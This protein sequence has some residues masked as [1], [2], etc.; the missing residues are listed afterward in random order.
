M[1]REQLTEL[2]YQGLETELGGTQVYETAL[3]C[4]QNDELKEEWEI[5]LGQ[6]K[7]QV[8]IVRRLLEAFEL[9]RRGDDSWPR[10]RPAHWQSLVKAMEMALQ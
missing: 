5:Y 2:L 1:K 6:T 8:E 4:V 3:R 10:H 7:T 9:R